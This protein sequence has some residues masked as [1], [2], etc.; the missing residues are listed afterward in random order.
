MKYGPVLCFQQIQQIA[1]DVLKINIL[2]SL[3]GRQPQPN[4]T[5]LNDDLHK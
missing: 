4:S 2:F 3:F 1:D 5:C